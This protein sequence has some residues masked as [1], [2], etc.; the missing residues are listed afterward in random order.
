VGDDHPPADDRILTQF[1]HLATS[2]FVPDDS[3]TPVDASFIVAP[4]LARRSDH[5]PIILHHMKTHPTF[6]KRSIVTPAT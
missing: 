5:I 3:K 4:P 6:L 1:R 2:L